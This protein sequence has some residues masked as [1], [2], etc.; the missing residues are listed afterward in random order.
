MAVLEQK[1]AQQTV[2][3]KFSI[4][5]QVM[6]G[7]V[8][9]MD[10]AAILSTAVIFH[11]IFVG[12]VFEVSDIYIVAIVFIWL[13]CLILMNFGGLYQ[14]DAILRP[15]A[16]VDKFLLAFATAFLFLLAAAFSIKITE[17]FS[18]LWLGSFA[19]G[20]GAATL[21]ARLCMAG[22][23][24][25]MGDAHLFTRRVVVAGAGEQLRV[26][27]NHFNKFPSRFVTVLGVFADR[28]P[29]S[30]T[31]SDRFAVL[32]Q[33]DDVQNFIR[34]NAVD[35][36]IIALPW[37]SD[38]QISALLDRLRD[39]P[40]NVYLST[41]LVGFRLP[42]HPPPDHFG[43]V[44]LVEIM[45]RPL[46]GWGKV[47]KAI[48]DYGLGSVLTLLL[49]PV[50]AL[51]AIAIK[52][53][54]RG[55]VLYR[56]ER[57]GFVNRVFIINKFR[58]MR[59]EEAPA[60]GRTVQATRTD[61]RV[62]RVGR[63]L[64]RTSLDEL[65]QLFN[66]LNGTMSLVGPRPHAIDHNEEYSQLIRGY[67]ARH[68]VKPGMTGWAQVNGLRGETRTVEAMEARIRYDI[69]YVENWSL[70]FDL[71]IMART[72]VVLLNRHNAY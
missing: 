66:V 57:Y 8:V 7:L 14:F 12:D 29:D 5:S 62:T 52:L 63:F 24:R 28:L 47:R 17:T 59:Y 71:Q 51:I 67:F 21:G 35:D 44:P 38:Q 23:I 40:V 64:R 34:S 58:S 4:S 72:A 37:A 41:D 10:S 46:A 3:R 13:S 48:L 11:E 18:R 56:Q 32:G 22:V 43:D 9:A 30:K 65:P 69:Y 33:L 6:P 49:L 42:F 60:P 53:D 20:A 15:Q 54:S 19:L 50:M 61:P 31:E 16:F 70:L 2:R 36:A 26:L 25:Q 45:G 39:L 55:P 27:L 68:R 1:R